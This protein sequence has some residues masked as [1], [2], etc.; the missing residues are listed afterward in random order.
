MI[1]QNGNTR[2]DTGLVGEDG[3]SGCGPAEYSVPA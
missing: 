3:K 2:G 1:N